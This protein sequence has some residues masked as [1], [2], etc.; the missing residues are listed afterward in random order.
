MVLAAL[1][2]R[3]DTD[4]FFV[5]FAIPNA[6]RQ[7][8]AEGTVSGAVMPVLAEVRERQGDEGG[9]E[10]Y[11]ALRGIWLLALLVTTVLGF[12]LI[13]DGLRARLDPRALRAMSTAEKRR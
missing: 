7:L 13:A 8:L 11:R 1:F 6:L 3:S 12:T 5:A 9:R 10:F 2:Q 4:V